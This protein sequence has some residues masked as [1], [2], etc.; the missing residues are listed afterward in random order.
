VQLVAAARAGEAG[1]SETATEG[2]SHPVEVQEHPT[3][4][5]AQTTET[6]PPAGQPESGGP[7]S[8]PTEPRPVVLDDLLFGGVG[9]VP[10]DGLRSPWASSALTARVESTVSG[11]MRI[12]A[13]GRWTMRNGFGF[14]ASAALVRAA[15]TNLPDNQSVAGFGNINATVRTPAL[16]RRHVA[17]QGVVGMVIPTSTSFLDHAIEVDDQYADVKNGGTVLKTDQRP[18]S[19]VGREWRLEPA[20]LLGIRLRRFTLSMVQGASLRVSPDLGAAYAGGLVVNA[21][22]VQALRFVSFAAWQVNYLG[23][24]INPGSSTPDAGGAVGG[25]FEALIPGGKRGQVRLALLGRV[26]LGEGGAAIYGRGAVGFTF[27][28]LFN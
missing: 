13:G 14:D 4:T 9:E 3:Q 18:P 17:L 20:I 23:I 11:S 28:Y 27:G 7:T 22:L 26:G 21:E 16:R 19:M 25:G 8:M 15:V 5:A 2:P 6:S 1:Q 12:V 24:P 10:F